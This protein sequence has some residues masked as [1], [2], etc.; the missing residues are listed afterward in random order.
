MSLK[1]R[2]KPAFP[3]KTPGYVA[4]TRRSI[5]R[6]VENHL[7]S[8][9][10]PAARLGRHGC[11]GPCGFHQLCWP[12]EAG[13]SVLHFLRPLNLRIARWL[14]VESLAMIAT[15]HGRHGD[16]AVVANVRLG[17]HERCRD[18]LALDKRGYGGR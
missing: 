5:G 8:A 11:P 13:F 17:Q 7:T 6:T 4:L 12:G 15:H 10:V 9:E 3:D 16:G 2:T 18:L 1:S 14:G